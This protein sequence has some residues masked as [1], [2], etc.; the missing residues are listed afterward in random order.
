[1]AYRDFTFEKLEKD[2]HLS[3]VETDLFSSVPIV[4]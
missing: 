4:K 2:L 1:M 3:I